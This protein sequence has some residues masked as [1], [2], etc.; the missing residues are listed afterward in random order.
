LLLL[1]LQAN[2]LGRLEVN[3]PCGDVGATTFTARHDLA[4]DDGE[5]LRRIGRGDED[6]MAAFYR[7]H[8]RV[9]FAQVLLKIFNGGGYWLCRAAGAPSWPLGEDPVQAPLK[10]APGVREVWRGGPGSGCG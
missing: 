2:P 9:V 6:A 10:A 1:T 8:G 5:L 3:D 7:G 4:C